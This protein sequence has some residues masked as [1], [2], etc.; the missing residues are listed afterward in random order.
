MQNGLGNQ[1]FLYA[2][3]KQLQKQ[4]PSSKVKAHIS[5]IPQ[6]NKYKFSDYILEDIFNITI[7]K[8]TWKRACKLANYYPEDGPFYR[9][10]F[11]IS[12][13]IRG[14]TGPKITHIEQDD[15]TAYYS[16]LF[17]LNPLYSYYIQGGFVNERYLEGIED[18]LRKDFCFKNKLEGQNL[19]LYN[20]ISK[21]NA[22]SIHIR[23]GDYIQ[24]N[25]PLA[26][27]KYYRRAIEVI[28]KEI[29]SPVF[30]VFSNDIDY[31]Y[32]LF[33]DKTNFR[34]VSG[35]QGRNSYIDMQLMSVCKHNIIANSTFS[36][37]GA[38]L[39]DNPTKMVIAPNISI[40]KY[41]RNPVA[42][43]DWI[44]IDV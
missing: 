20:E 31:A 22:V 26:S 6:K 30:F 18:E 2:V 34:M 23:R 35:N 4:Y 10:L 44:K 8:C 3:I 11:P 5:N 9:L 14:V 24:L 40:G 37:W 16:E 43:K 13:I 38:Y 15:N 39:N 1:M 19:S 25:F 17:T 33:G 21:S 29:E 12:H 27:D 36:F 7:D 28:N 41:D 42:C 32:E